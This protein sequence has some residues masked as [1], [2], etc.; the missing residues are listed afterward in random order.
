MRVRGAVR[1]A[2]AQD[3][4]R[5]AALLAALFA[6]HSGVGPRFALRRGSEDALRALLAAR[7]RDPRARVLAFAAGEDIPGLCVAGLRRRPALFE[8]TE[9]GE[10]EHLVVRESARREGV[11][12]ALVEAALGWMRAQGIRRVEIQ[13]ERDN[14]AGRAFWRALGFAAAMDVLDRAL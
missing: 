7:L 3:L 1:P 8:E 4:D 5:L 9:R 14:P 11:G 10:I 12:R 13:V 6:H 2:R